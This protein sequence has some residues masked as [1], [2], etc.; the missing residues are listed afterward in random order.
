MP[1]HPPRFHVR[2]FVLATVLAYVLLAVMILAG[3]THSRSGEDQNL[4][5][6]KVI[7]QFSAEF[8]AFGLKNY[9]SATTPGYHIVMAAVHR[10]V[11]AD[12]LVLRLLST[13]PTAAL[14][15][16]LVGL[17]AARRPMAEAVCLALPLLACPYILQSGMY[18]LPDNLAWLLVLVVVGVALA[19]VQ[20][21]RRWAIAGGLLVLLVAVRQIHIWAAA[22]VWV[23]AWFAAPVM[24][25]RAVGAGG[26]GGGGWLSAMRNEEL[27]AGPDA[28]AEAELAG[29]A[30]L[31]DVPHSLWRAGVAVVMTL[32]AFVVLGAFAV[33]WGGLTPA[34][35]RDA[36]QTL[37]VD[38]GP[39]VPTN[40][41]GLSPATPAFMLSL[42]AIYLAFCVPLMWGTLRGLLGRKW[43]GIGL[44][45][46]AAV[47]AVL[48]LVPET[49]YVLRPHPLRIGGLWNAVKWLQDRGVTVLGRTSPLIVVMSAVGAAG[50]FAVLVGAQRQARWVLAVMLVA[51][52]A[53]CSAQALTW[54]RYF[55]PLL[56][57]WVALAVA[58][59]AEAVG[60]RREGWQGLIALGGPLALAGL[61]GVLSVAAFAGRFG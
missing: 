19:P 39:T 16:T 37:G 11:T 46:A 52:L 51:F 20:S 23:G 34:A 45:L 15:G 58:S 10:F 41:G 55:E 26:G 36:Q 27:P 2:A 38:G 4:F 44:G 42:L 48:A 14:F 40:V 53:A 12:L 35:F 33:L 29:A 9:L 24:G 22:T 54:Q 21:W 7:E 17:L 43:F 61:M 56:L 30:V 18:L 13:V 28:A 5:H 59:R 49:T 32:P 50:V 57:M 60:G 25:D 8:P 31:A 3:V 6:L 47:G 1:M